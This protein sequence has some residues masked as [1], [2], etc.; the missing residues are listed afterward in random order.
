LMMW[1]SNFTFSVDTFFHIRWVDEI[2]LFFMRGKDCFRQT[3]TIW[4]VTWMTVWFKSP[5][6]QHKF[7]IDRL[8]FSPFIADS[9][10]LFIIKFLLLW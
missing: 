10:H 2:D 7:V 4:S 5:S 3:E 9:S 1:L 6:N 8:L